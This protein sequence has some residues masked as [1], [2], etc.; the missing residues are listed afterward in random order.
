MEDA[1]HKKKLL[2]LVTVAVT[3]I[4]SMALLGYLSIRFLPSSRIFGDTGTSQGSGTQSVENRDRLGDWND[5]TGVRGTQSVRTKYILHKDVQKHI[6]RSIVTYRGK[7]GG[8]KIMIDVIVLDLD[9][10]V[11][12]SRT[13]DI[14]RAKKRFN[15]G[16]ERFKLISA[17][18][19]R[20]LVWHY[21]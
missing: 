1:S 6:G 5:G 4:G 16:D 15:I 12:Y 21:H 8:A 13:L 19:L 18:G 7:A 14:A 10:H 2:S 17:S 3:L 9:P 11:T 20:M